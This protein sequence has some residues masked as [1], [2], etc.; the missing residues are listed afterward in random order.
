MPLDDQLKMQ[1]LLGDF[2]Q[3]GKPGRHHRHERKSVGSGIA[4][5]ASVVA[6]I[7]LSIFA[8]L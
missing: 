6:V 1:I 8:V 2:D 5:A 3:P 4:I 7:L